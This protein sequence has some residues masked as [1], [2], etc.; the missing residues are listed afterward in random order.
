M[1][2]CKNKDLKLYYK[3]YKKLKGKH[4]LKNYKKILDSF[5]EI[6]LESH[7]FGDLYKPKKFGKSKYWKSSMDAQ[8][9]W[10]DLN[11]LTPKESIKYFCS[12]DNIHAYS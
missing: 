7:V 8:F 5:F 11:K 12:V 2:N 9:Y 3:E 4:K 10:R 1:K 6:T